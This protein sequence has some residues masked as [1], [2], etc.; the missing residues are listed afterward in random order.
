MMNDQ[1]AG[2][3]TDKRLEVNYE[4]TGS[5]YMVQVPGGE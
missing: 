3:C 1:K 5:Y 2:S 4:G